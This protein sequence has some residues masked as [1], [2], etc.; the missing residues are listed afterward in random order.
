MSPIFIYLAIA[1]VVGFLCGFWAVMTMD[2][3]VPNNAFGEFIA[4]WAF[5]LYRPLF[6][7]GIAL[8]VLL[9]VGQAFADVIGLSV[10]VNQE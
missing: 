8:I 3:A 7:G 4:A 5:Y 10:S 6:F 9:A 1:V 2:T